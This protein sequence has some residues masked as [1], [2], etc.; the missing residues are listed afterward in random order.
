MRY[1]LFNLFGFLKC[2]ERYGSREVK[3]LIAPE[4]YQRVD[5]VEVRMLLSLAM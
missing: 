2:V 4:W 1:A 5:A 3:V